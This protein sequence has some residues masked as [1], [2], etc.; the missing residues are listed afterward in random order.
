M[1]PAGPGDGGVG[2]RATWAL[3]VAFEGS[4]HGVCPHQ[5]VLWHPVGVGKRG[6]SLRSCIKA[7]GV[8]L[9]DPRGFSSGY[10]MI[11]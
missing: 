9:D 8:G 10:S 6:T 2:S 4:F 5:K 7:V 11:F 3:T 1:G